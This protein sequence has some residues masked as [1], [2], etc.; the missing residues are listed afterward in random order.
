MCSLCG[1]KKSAVPIAFGFGFHVDDSDTQTHSNHQ[2]YKRE[3]FMPSFP[4][5]LVINLIPLNCIGL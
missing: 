1:N 2:K 3:G 5:V 4:P